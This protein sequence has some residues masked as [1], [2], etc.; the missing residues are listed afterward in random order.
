MTDNPEITIEQA[1]EMTDGVVS[2]LRD[3]L[4]EHL[5]DLRAVNITTDR[6][7]VPES[8]A[9]A[10]PQRAGHMHRLAVACDNFVNALRNVH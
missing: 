3:M 8:K 5:A 1:I 4:Q 9:S 7:T 10:D 6:A 2:E